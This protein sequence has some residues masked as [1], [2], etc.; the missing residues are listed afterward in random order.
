MLFGFLDSASRLGLQP[1]YY[2]KL[3]EKLSRLL[4]HLRGTSRFS[5]KTLILIFRQRT[6]HLCMAYSLKEQNGK[7]NN[8]FS[9]YF[10]F[11]LFLFFFSKNRYVKKNNLLHRDYE[12]SYISE[13]DPMKLHYPMPTI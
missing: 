2:N 10:Y 9:Y 7:E 3:Q 4:I 8:F 11:I 12:K 1:H 13:A 6:E 5:L